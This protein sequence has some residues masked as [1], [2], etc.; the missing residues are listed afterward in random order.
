MRKGAQSAR[1]TDLVVEQGRS[2]LLCEAV[3]VLLEAADDASRTLRAHRAVRELL[4][5]KQ[6]TRVQA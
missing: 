5:G 6:G 2:A 4:R 3:T 1:L